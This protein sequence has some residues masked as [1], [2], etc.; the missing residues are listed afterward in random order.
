MY[1]CFLC[2]LNKKEIFQDFYFEEERVLFSIII[3]M[4]FILMNLLWYYIQ[5]NG[6]ILI[7][8]DNFYRFFNLV[9]K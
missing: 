6:G 2:L 5:V 9:I 3:V 4:E 1:I 8:V 7:W